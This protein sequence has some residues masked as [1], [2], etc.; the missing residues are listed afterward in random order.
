[1][2]T[3]IDLWQSPYMDDKEKVIQALLQVLWST[4]VINK[5][6]GTIE[7]NDN[8]VTLFFNEGYSAINHQLN[9]LCAC[10]GIQTFIDKINELERE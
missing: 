10:I 6:P 2:I 1:M 7:V 4:N 5:R 8:I 9:D 3:E